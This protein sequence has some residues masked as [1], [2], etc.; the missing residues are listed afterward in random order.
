VIAGAVLAAGAG[1][2]F[3][4]IKQLALYDG[5]PL[6]RRACRTALAAGLSPVIV[7]VGAHA[8]RVTAAVRDLAVRIR[9]NAQW[10]AGLASSIRCAAAELEP[11]I[12]ALALVLADQPL[13][14]AAHLVALCERRGGALVAATRHGDVC[15]VPAVFDRALF[16]RLAALAG[17]R[18]ARELIAASRRVEL[19]FAGAAFDVDTPEALA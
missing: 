10:E 14:T 19:P 5:E 4:A 7:V 13:I 11:A 8:E 1:R 17:D 6:V 16:G 18:G 2:R 3:G 12:A 9:F 15:G